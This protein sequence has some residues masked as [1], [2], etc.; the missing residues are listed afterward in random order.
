M[1]G[2]KKFFLSKGA[3]FRGVSE[4]QRN[5]FTPNFPHYN[6]LDMDFII[7]TAIRFFEE[8]G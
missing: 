5:T 1:A 6:K 7:G 8:Y 2:Q 4:L 3:L